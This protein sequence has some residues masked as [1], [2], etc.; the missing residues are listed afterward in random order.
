L[1]FPFPHQAPLDCGEAS[2][3]INNLAEAAPLHENFSQQRI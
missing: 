1:F 3:E 2:Y